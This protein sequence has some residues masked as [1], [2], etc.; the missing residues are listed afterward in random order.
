M[1][2]GV[3]LPVKSFVCVRVRAHERVCVPGCVH[4]YMHAC[5]CVF[6]MHL[7]SRDEPQ[8]RPSHFEEQSRCKIQE[9]CMPVNILFNV[10]TSR[11]QEKGKILHSEYMQ[12]HVMRNND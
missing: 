10:F 3:Y 7:I 12:V 8:T 2:A 6:E 9:C 1:R 4:A 5:L 11:N